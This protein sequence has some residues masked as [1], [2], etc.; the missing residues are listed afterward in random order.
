MTRSIAMLV[1]A[2]VVVTLAAAGVEAGA[3][4]HVYPGAGTPI[5]D[6]IDGAGEGDTIYVHAGTYYENVDVNRRLTLI[7]DGEEVVTVRAE[8]KYED[9]FHVTAD[10]VNISGFVVTGVTKYNSGFYLNN[11]DHC[12]ISDNSASNDDG[13]GIYMEDSSNNTLIGNTFV[14][15]GLLLHDFRINQIFHHPKCHNLYIESA[16]IIH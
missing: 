10:W 4:L 5:Q 12:N 16:Q 13:Y 9:A 14:N 1:A 6:A 8:L 3:E 11:A 7:G 2:A 15:D